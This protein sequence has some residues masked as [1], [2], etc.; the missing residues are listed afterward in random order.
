MAV[1]LIGG[2][3]AVGNQLVADDTE[4]PLIQIFDNRYLLNLQDGGQYIN[5]LPDT[6]DENFYT[7]MKPSA[8][9]KFSRNFTLF[10]GCEWRNLADS[11]M[12][13]ESYTRTHAEFYQFHEAYFQAMQEEA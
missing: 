2:P 8:F 7:S 4:R 10:P 6:H 13:V 3:D 5:H 11:F 9:Q 12:E 1:S